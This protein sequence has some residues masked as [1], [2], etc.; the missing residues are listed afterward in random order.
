MKKNGFT[1]LELLIGV[2][3]ISVVMVFLFRLLHDIQNESSTNTYIVANQTNRDEMISKLSKIMLE[4]DDV[5]YLDDNNLN[6][7]RNIKLTFC[8]NNVLN[9]FVSRN[10]VYFVYGGKTYR[11]PMKDSDAYYDTDVSYYTTSLDLIDILKINIR[12]G[13]KGLKNTVLDDIEIIGYVNNL[14]ISQN[15]ATDFQ[16]TGS[17]QVFIV[18]AD[19]VYRIEAWGAEGGRGMCNGGLCGAGGKGGYA[20][21]NIELHRGDRLYVYVGQKGKNA[22]GNNQTGTFN[23]G[24]GSSHD[25][26]DN[27]SAGTGGGATDVR[28]VGDTA[29]DD[30]ESLA[31]RIIVAGGGGGNSYGYKSGAGGGLHG[32]NGNGSNAPGATQTSGNEFGIGTTGTGRGDSDG[33]AGGGGGYWGGV[34][35][36]ALNGESASGGSGYISGHTG[37]VAIKSAND[38]SP[39]SGC[40]DGTSDASCSIHYSGRRFNSTVLT[41]GNELIPTHDGLSTMEGNSGNGYV[42]ITF[43]SKTF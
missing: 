27:E 34:S 28:L 37:C 2:S 31:S 39:K 1:L 6:G 21:G 16:Y 5:C 30:P 41:T 15:T 10:E 13:K 43:V 20:A 40:S 29:W 14:S 35:Y 36:D 24:G 26:S 9:I 7:T 18:R 11:Y 42:K 4:N 38:T 3:L 25:Y 32:E 12:T 19:G 23:G 33:V 8:N 17:S 22:N